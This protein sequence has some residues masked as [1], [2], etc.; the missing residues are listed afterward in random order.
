VKRNSQAQGFMSGPSSAYQTFWSDRYNEL[1]KL[2]KK[3]QEEIN[4]YLTQQVFGAS[5]TDEDDEDK[6][7]QAAFSQKMQQQIEARNGGEQE[8][9]SGE[10]SNKNKRQDDSGEGGSD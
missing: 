9:E 2:S 10:E 4:G 3:E 1:Q 6:E 5:L 7:M 8:A